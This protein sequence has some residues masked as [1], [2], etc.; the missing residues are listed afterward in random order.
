[1]TVWTTAAL[2][3]SATFSTPS[4][5]P[6]V[7]CPSSMVQHQVLSGKPMIRNWMLTWLLK[8]FHQHSGID[9]G[10]HYQCAAAGVPLDMAPPPTP[11]SGEAHSTF[12]P[13]T[14]MVTR[15]LLMQLPHTQSPHIPL[16]P[17]MI[18]FPNKD[19]PGCKLVGSYHHN[20][21]LVLKRIFKVDNMALIF[22]YGL[23]M[24]ITLRTLVIQ[25]SMYFDGFC[26]MHESFPTMY[27]A[28][29]I[30]FDSNPDLFVPCLVQLAALGTQLSCWPLQAASVGWIF[31]MY[32]HLLPFTAPTPL[33]DL[34]SRKNCLY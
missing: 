16:W 10:Q 33:A 7:S 19:N 14:Q 27:V 17:T 9:W 31:G 29:L 3:D 30:R 5:M 22:P 12:N 23:K 21:G 11:S 2:A 28:V 34:W 25:I 15:S 6:P 20:W 8:C 4:N 24:G 13:H 32:R 18:W 1:M 26:L